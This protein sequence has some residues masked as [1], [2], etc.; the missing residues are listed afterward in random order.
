VSVAG[1]ADESR[2]CDKTYGLLYRTFRQPNEIDNRQLQRVLIAVTRVISG[3]R[4]FGRGLTRI[5]HVRRITLVGCSTPRHLQ[6]VYDGVQ[7]QMLC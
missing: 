2:T 5:I 6:T 4:K 1:D 3:T 7:A